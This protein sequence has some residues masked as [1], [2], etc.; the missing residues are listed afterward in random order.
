MMGIYGNYYGFPNIATSSKFLN[1]NPVETIAAKSQSR[2]LMLL[3]SSLKE[4]S[5][6]EHQIEK[7]N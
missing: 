3:C 1:K 2:L 4:L 6:K 7:K 5:M